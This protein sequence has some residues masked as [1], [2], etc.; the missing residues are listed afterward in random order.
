LLKILITLEQEKYKNVL[1]IKKFVIIFI[2][3]NSLWKELN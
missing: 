2:S 1:V 3:K